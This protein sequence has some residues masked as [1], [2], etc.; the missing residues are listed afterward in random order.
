MFILI[1]GWGG[2]PGA[3]RERGQASPDTLRRKEALPGPGQGRGDPARK[4]SGRTIPRTEGDKE[5]ATERTL[6]IGTIE[7]IPLNA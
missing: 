6:E 1:Q 5:L 4:G 3:Q 2:R 7:I